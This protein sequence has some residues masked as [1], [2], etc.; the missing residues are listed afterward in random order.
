MLQLFE[1]GRKKFPFFL[2]SLFTQNN[3]LNH[4]YVV[5][6][7]HILIRTKFVK[8]L[9]HFQQRKMF[10][11]IFFASNKHSYKSKHLD[12][13]TRP[14]YV[15]YSSASLLTKGSH[16]ASTKTMDQQSRFEK[17]KKYLNQLMHYLAQGSFFGRNQIQF[18]I[19]ILNIWL[20]FSVFCHFGFC[21]L[22][23][24]RMCTTKTL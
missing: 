1:V 12:N 4:F 22:L 2:F 17:N 7:Q 11:P 6:L 21:C 14:F 15:I 13:H 23:C 20:L 19:W 8:S 3:W 9:K 10:S 24:M 5:F 16:I 18:I